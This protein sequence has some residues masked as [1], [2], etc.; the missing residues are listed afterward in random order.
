MP[1]LP[2]LYLLN[3]DRNFRTPFTYTQEH[4]APSSA[5]GISTF[6]TDFRGVNTGQSKHLTSCGGARVALVARRDDNGCKSS[7]S[8]NDVFECDQCRGQLDKDLWILY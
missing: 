6:P 5:L 4:K 8:I 2:D 7:R 1:E 3:S